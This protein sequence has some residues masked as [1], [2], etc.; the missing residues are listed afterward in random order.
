MAK[1]DQ[2]VIE[3]GKLYDVTFKGPRGTLI[4]GNLRFDGFNYEIRPP[5]FA[6]KKQ[7]DG[8]VEAFPEDLSLPGGSLSFQVGRLEQEVPN[9]TIVNEE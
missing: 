3:E 9:I 6:F 2:L 1:N 4:V 8:T 7:I 5:Y